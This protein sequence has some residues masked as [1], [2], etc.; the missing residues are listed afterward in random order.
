MKA[1]GREA[2]MEDR[3]E[4]FSVFLRTECE[5]ETQRIFARAYKTE[6]GYHFSKDGANFC[7]SFDA[8]KGRLIVSRSGEMSYFLNLSRREEQETGI[9][10]SFGDLPVSV[11]VQSLDF[12]EQHGGEGV[13][14]RYTLDFSGFVQHHSFRFTVK[15]IFIEE[16]QGV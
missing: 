9:E 13:D 14:C 15:P 12:F 5:G 10:T 11:R 1:D 16:D 3:K 4:R 6:R 7:I 2:G 8:H